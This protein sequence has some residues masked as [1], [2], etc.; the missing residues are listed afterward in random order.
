MLTHNARRTTDDDG[1]QPIAIGH[2]S[3]SGDL[4]TELLVCFDTYANALQSPVSIRG[5]S[6]SFIT[7]NKCHEDVD[8][9]QYIR[10]NSLFQTEK[11]VNNE[12][13]AKLTKSL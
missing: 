8:T 7:G 1:R 9:I 13:I 12:T 2:L 10:Q 6:E 3:H 5:Y 4:K 11:I